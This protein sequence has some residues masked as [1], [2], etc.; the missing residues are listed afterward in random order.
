MHGS[1]VHWCTGWTKRGGTAR[2]VTVGTVC[3]R[4]V[5]SRTVGGVV[6]VVDNQW[7]GGRVCVGL[8]GPA[9]KA[10]HEWDRRRGRRATVWR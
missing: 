3:D 1:S 2:G 8:L 6:S 7:D 10:R 9:A 4:S 5:R